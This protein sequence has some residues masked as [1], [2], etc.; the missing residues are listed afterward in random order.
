VPRFA[1]PLSGARFRRRMNYILP[2]SCVVCFK[3]FIMAA[4]RVVDGL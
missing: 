1:V 3:C 4:Q 2:F